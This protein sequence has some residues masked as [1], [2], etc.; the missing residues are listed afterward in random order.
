MEEK[1]IIQTELNSQ[2]ELEDKA[3]EQYTAADIQVLE[4]LEA[5]RKRPGMYIGTTGPAGLHHLVWEIVDNAID[6]ALAGYCDKITVTI[7]K[8]ETDRKS[9]RLNSSH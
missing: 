8:G 6:E 5:V 3:N 2:E 9:T 4:G 1:E 7:N